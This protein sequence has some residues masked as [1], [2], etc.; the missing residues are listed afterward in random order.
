MY[1]FTD[2]LLPLSARNP[3]CPCSLQGM[4]LAYIWF[5]FVVGNMHTNS[6]WGGMTRWNIGDFQ[7]SGPILYDTRTVNTCNLAFV[8]PH[9]VYNAK[10]K[11]SWRNDGI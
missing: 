5:S 8:K 11:P 4:N 1:G 7:D 2:A 6:C 10:N 9:R 3:G